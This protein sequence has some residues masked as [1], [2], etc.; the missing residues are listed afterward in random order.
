[1]AGVQIQRLEVG[2]ENNDRAA[3]PGTGGREAGL[4][5]SNAR[6]TDKLL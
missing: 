5:T 1:M 4:E 3:E 6:E 2:E